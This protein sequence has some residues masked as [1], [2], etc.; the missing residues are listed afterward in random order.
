MSN[1]RLCPARRA[2]GLWVL[3]CSGG[4]AKTLLQGLI[5][6]DVTRLDDGNGGGLPCISAA[7]LNPK[8]NF[9]F[10]PLEN[11]SHTNLKYF[12]P[13]K[14]VEFYTVEVF[15]SRESRLAEHAGSVT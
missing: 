6:N 10:F 3:G 7:F 1:Y 12:V 2:L 15:S 9:P 14:R 8:V 5:T 13:K 11:L 4:D